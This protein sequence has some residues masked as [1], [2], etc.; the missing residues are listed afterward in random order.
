MQ[1][2]I[3]VFHDPLVSLTDDEDLVNTISILFLQ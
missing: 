2:S 3:L 1:F